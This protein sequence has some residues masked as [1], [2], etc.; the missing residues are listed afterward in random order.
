MTKKFLKEK[1]LLAVP[2]DKGVGIC[3]MKKSTYE[4]KMDEILK[5][6]QFEKW[7]QPRSNSKDLIQKEEERINK[8]LRKMLCSG[9]ITEQLH[10]DLRSRGGQ[11]PRLYGLAK[12]HKPSVPMQP[13]LLMPGSPYFQ[14][15]N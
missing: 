1:E 10:N 4:E 13:V 2:F 6:D 15:A 8:T 11:P 5:L 9:D 7:V 12:V 3:V 14:I